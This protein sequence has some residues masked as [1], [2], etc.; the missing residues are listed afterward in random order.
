MQLRS[1]QGVKDADELQSDPEPELEEQVAITGD[2]KRAKHEIVTKVSFIY[3]N[4]MNILNM[5]D[6]AISTA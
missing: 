1:E 6:Y 2:N 5:E 4:R 3:T